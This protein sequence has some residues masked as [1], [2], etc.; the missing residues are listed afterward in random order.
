MGAWKARVGLAPLTIKDAE[1]FERAKKIILSE[2]PV[3]TPENKIQSMNIKL[4]D[5]IKEKLDLYE[6]E[7]KS[8]KDFGHITADMAIPVEAMK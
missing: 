1:T 5:F 8:T 3:V 4:A 6:T 2:P 7:W